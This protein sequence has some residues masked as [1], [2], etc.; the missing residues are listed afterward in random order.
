M[1]KYPRV[2]WSLLDGE[3]YDL[4]IVEVKRGD[5]RLETHDECDKMKTP[6]WIEVSNFRGISDDAANSRFCCLIKY[7]ATLGNF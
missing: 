1:K 5:Y 3:F 6:I 4:R 7:L 2:V